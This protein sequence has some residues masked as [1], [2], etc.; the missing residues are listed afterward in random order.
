[1]TRYTKE[2]WKEAA[3]IWRSKNPEKEMVAAHEVIEISSGRKVPIGAKLQRM[4]RKINDLDEEDKAFWDSVGLSIQNVATKDRYTEEEYREAAMIWRRQNPTKKKIKTTDEITL[5]SGKRIPLGNRFTHM[6][7]NIE[8]QSKETIEFWKDYGLLEV[9][10]VKKIEEYVQLFDGDRKQAEKVIAILKDLESH[11]RD[12]IDVEELAKRFP[13]GEEEIKR[14]LARTIKD[15]KR[16]KKNVEFKMQGSLQQFCLNHQYDYPTVKKV[17]RLADMCPYDTLEQL[18]N[19]ILINKKRVKGQFSTWIY[20][21]Y[22]YTINI[23]L[24]YLEFFP[25]EVLESMSTQIRSLEYILRHQVFKKITEKKTEEWLEK[26]YDAILDKID[27]HATSIDMIKNCLLHLEKYQEKYDLTKEETK[28][29]SEALKRYCNTVKEYQ[30]IEVGLETDALKKTEKINKYHFEIEDI[31]ESF[32]VPLYFEEGKLL[33]KHNKL[34]ARR[35]LIKIYTIDWDYYTDEEK[36]KIIRA[37]RLTK[38]EI[39]MIES[40]RQEINEEAKRIN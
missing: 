8:K 22:G 37:N 14:I 21:K 33:G 1:M 17:L 31:E 35:E 24:R 20:E 3:I 32:Y 27:L 16:V 23:V 13:I 36:E 38:E 9:L 6:R 15:S 2:E 39:T 10:G 4:R 29:I 34:R 11:K 28:H 19:R 30:I 12:D 18:V 26:I 25:S 40:L 7:K 5:P